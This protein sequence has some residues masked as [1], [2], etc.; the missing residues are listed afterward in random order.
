MGGVGD[1][2]RP[3]LETEGEGKCDVSADVNLPKEERRQSEWEERF[4]FPSRRVTQQGVLGGLGS[5]L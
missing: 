4:T 2:E 1:G 3:S 5:S